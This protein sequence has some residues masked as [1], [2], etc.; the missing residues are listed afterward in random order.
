MT[1]PRRLRSQ[2]RTC[3]IIQVISSALTIMSVVG[4]GVAAG[5][6]AERF[7]TV[8]GDVNAMKA[9]LSAVGENVQS[10]KSDVSVVRSEQRSLDQRVGRIERLLDGGRGGVP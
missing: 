7:D 9:Q 10:V 4:L 2:V 5:R 8:G 3:T 6:Y 1:G